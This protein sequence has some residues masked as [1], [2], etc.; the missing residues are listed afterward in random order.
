M[1]FERAAL[2]I[3]LRK[4]SF[5]S[6]SLSASHN[7]NHYKGVRKDTFLQAA[8]WHLPDSTEDENRQLYEWVTEKLKREEGQGIYGLIL[9]TAQEFLE[10]REDGIY[11]RDRNWT[12]RSQFF[13]WKELAVSLGQ[14]IFMMALLADELTDGQG[15][16]EGFRD[17][18]C[19]LFPRIGSESLRELL[20]K[21]GG[22]GLAENHFHLK[23]SFPVFLLNWVCLMNHVGDGNDFFHQMKEYRG[24]ERP[25]GP[26]G[27]SGRPETDL[28]HAS[29]AA[30]SYRLYLY[31]VYSHIPEKQRIPVFHGEDM[32][33]AGLSTLQNRIEYYRSFMEPKW[34][35][36]RF[37]WSVSPDYAL[38][39]QWESCH[40]RDEISVAGERCFLFRCF[41]E[42]WSGKSSFGV[43]ERNLFYR[44]LL[45]SFRIR[46]ELIQVNRLRGFGNFAA[47]QNRKEDVIDCYPEYQPHVIRLTACSLRRQQNLSSLEMRISPKSRAYQT[48]NR[49]AEYEREIGEGEEGAGVNRNHPRR[50]PGKNGEYFYVLHFPKKQEKRKEFA[51]RNYELRKKMERQIQEQKRLILFEQSNYKFGGVIP[52]VRGYDTCSGEIGCRPEVFGWSYRSIQAFARENQADWIHWT[53]H[54]GED[55][56]DLVDGLRAID[57]A[58]RFCQLPP[59]SRL[60]HGMALGIDAEQYYQM[61]QYKIL[62]PAQ[63]LLDNLAWTLGFCREYGIVIRPWLRKKLEL[64]FD[65]LLEKIYGVK[66]GG[67]SGREPLADPLPAAGPNRAEQEAAVTRVSCGKSTEEWRLYYESW[68]LRGDRPELYLEYEE[69][70]YAPLFDEALR[71]G[72]ERIRGDE[73][74]REYYRSYH[75]DSQARERGEKPEPFAVDR[76]YVELIGRMQEELRYRLTEQ[77]IGIECNPTSNYKI[78]PFSR[79]DEHPMLRMY[80][81]NLEE[82]AAS[83]MSISINTDDMGVFQT[84]LETEYA[85]MYVALRKSR[86]ERGMLK[87]PKEAVLQWLRDVKESG[88]RQAF[89]WANESEA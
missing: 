15:E 58:V 21:D 63:D 8:R 69:P 60:G 71:K 35:E 47:Y 72:L 89:G 10:T 62:L 48:L 42:I 9:E 6:V 45:I 11:Y 22:S 39:G 80:G 67:K 59:G 28:F 83:R 16:R 5:N 43:R 14:E 82:G 73:A 46:A 61:K 17:C 64:R 68:Q 31:E 20:G 38:D 74:C 76:A 88:R 33:E 40:D 78:G 34:D 57:E 27:G 85:A 65:E 77:R 13:H 50:S 53:Y 55:F 36:K 86:D 75:F 18:L 41:R 56:L 25:V 84:S 2:E 12:V 66:Q 19:A 87:Y 44:Y 1:D 37:R 54:A 7:G 51:P 29:V 70:V 81:K 49:I 52:Q 3:L 26:Q 32:D 79:F 4:I 30:A 24:E 23:G